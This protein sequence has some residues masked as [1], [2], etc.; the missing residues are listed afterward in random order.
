MSWNTDR[1][2][3]AGP[4]RRGDAPRVLRPRSPQP[5]A[6]LPRPLASLRYPPITG[7]EARFDPPPR[8]AVRGPA[9]IPERYSTREKDGTRSLECDEAPRIRVIIDPGMA[10]SRFEASSLR[11]RGNRP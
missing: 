2:P 8:V 11:G 6:E 3:L 4:A 10:G 1:E 7:A 9:V 5:M